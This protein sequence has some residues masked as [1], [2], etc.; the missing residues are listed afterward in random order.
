MDEKEAGNQTPM[1]E[2]R[3][4]EMPSPISQF[5]AGNAWD[6]GKVLRQFIGVPPPA[7]R[8]MPKL[9]IV[10]A[11]SQSLSKPSRQSKVGVHWEA[12]RSLDVTAAARQPD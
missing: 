10:D 1:S 9:T 11:N 7:A 4:I 8:I 3:Q 2:A 5:M 12:S 6:G